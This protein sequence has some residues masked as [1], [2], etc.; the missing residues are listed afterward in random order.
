M[1]AEDK[2]EAERDAMVRSALFA[3]LRVAACG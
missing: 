3:R 2:A 1:E